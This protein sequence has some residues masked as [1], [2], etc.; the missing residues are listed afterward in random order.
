MASRSLPLVLAFACIGAA[1]ALAYDDSLPRER[2]LPCSSLC[3]SWMGLG[4]AET[5]GPASDGPASEG[6]AASAPALS[7]AS[8]PPIALPAPTGVASP[9]ARPLARPIARVADKPRHVARQVPPR[10]VPAMAAVS[11]V[12]TIEPPPVL[13]APQ[14]PIVPAADPLAV[15]PATPAPVPAADAAVAPAPTPQAAANPPPLEPQVAVA[16]VSAPLPTPAPAPQTT[17]PAPAQGTPL[18]VKLGIYA[19]LAAL[20][21]WGLGRRRPHVDTSVARPPRRDRS[22]RVGQIGVQHAAVDAL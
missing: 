21:G 14:R 15:L 10:P 9:R 2:E 11:R 1:P 4:R 17:T 12:A 5:S 20:V 3:R 18:N 19:V 7:T 6:P 16:A 8:V 13:A 22:V